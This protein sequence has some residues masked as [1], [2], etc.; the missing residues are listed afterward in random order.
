MEI[1]RHPV[2][3]LEIKPPALLAYDTQREVADVQ[4]RNQFKDLRHDSTIPCLHGVSAFGTR[5]S[6]YEYDSATTYLLP[7][8]IFRPQTSLIT[9]VA[10]ITRWDCDVLDPEGANRLRGVV[11]KV[12]EMSTKVGGYGFP[13]QL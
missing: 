6:F 8:Q 7:G 4:M 11:D 3:F 13:K 1:N 9:D 10:P 12:K 2:F 5:L